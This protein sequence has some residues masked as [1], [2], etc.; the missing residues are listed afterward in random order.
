[1][2]KQFGAPVDEDSAANPF[3]ALVAKA[4]DNG[5]V[6]YSKAL[7]EVMQTDAGREAYAAANPGQPH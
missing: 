1:M 5:K 4:M 2:S 6:P 3:E 7:T